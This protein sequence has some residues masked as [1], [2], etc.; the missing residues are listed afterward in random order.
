MERGEERRRGGMKDS[1]RR[2]WEWRRIRAVCGGAEGRRVWRFE[3]GACGVE[4]GGERGRGRRWIREKRV[5][6]AYVER[7]KGIRVEGEVLMNEVLK[8]D[9]RAGARVGGVGIVGRSETVN[10]TVPV[11]S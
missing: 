1:R 10:A 6:W 3:M 8:K 11:S 9:S 5:R 7:R 4:V 2:A